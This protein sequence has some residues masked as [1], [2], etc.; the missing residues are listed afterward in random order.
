MRDARSKLTEAIRSI[1]EDQHHLELVTSE[2]GTGRARNASYPYT[3]LYAQRGTTTLL[4]IEAG[5]YPESAVLTLY[6]PAV[7]APDDS[8]WAARKL[9][10]G[11]SD[12]HRGR[13]E[14]H[15]LVEY[16]DGARIDTALWL[17]ETLL[18]QAPQN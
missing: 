10:R 1:I 2:G 4:T 6:G 14:F 17:I 9:Y 11:K 16:N 8:L 7:D 13:L 15:V 18:A 3:Q 5:W 12:S